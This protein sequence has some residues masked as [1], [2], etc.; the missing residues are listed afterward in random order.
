M[1]RPRP[2]HRRDSRVSAYLDPSDVDRLDR[3]AALEDRSRSDAARVII[4]R[5][6]D[7]FERRLVASG[8]PGAQR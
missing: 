4:R 2:D 7:D 8:D 5:A 3:L 1:P 6:L